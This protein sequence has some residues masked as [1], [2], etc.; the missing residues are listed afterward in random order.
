[1]MKEKYIKEMDPRPKGTEDSTQH[2]P[3]Q[4]E[5]AGRWAADELTGRAVEQGREYAKKKF[6]AARGEAQTGPEPVSNGTDSP[7]AEGV[8]R[9]QSA[10]EY[11]LAPTVEH[12]EAERSPTAPKERPQVDRNLPQFEA[13]FSLHVKGPSLHQGTGLFALPQCRFHWF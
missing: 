11:P 5:H 9:G 4:V 13:S 3:D 1:M 7:T 8:P 2:A 6:A 10:Q 12:R